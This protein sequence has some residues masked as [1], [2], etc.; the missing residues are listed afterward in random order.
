M[1]RRHGYSSLLLH[2]RMKNFL[3]LIILASLN[4]Q[5]QVA[6]VSIDEIRIPADDLLLSDGTV[7]SPEDAWS[8]LKEK[9]SD[10]LKGKDLP[11]SLIDLEP[12]ENKL[13]KNQIGAK[14]DKS[15]DDID[16]N[17]SD[18]VT[19]T[20]DLT[21]KDIFRF[22]AL[23]SE[24]RI[25][26][27]YLDKKMHVT[28]MRK[29]FLR[30]LGY[31]VPA[32]KHLEKLRVNFK[33]NDEK[34]EFISKLQTAT[35]GR[36]TRWVVE[37]ESTETSLF[38]RDVSA[39]QLN[40]QQLYNPAMG[41]PS[42]SLNSRT[43]R[44]LIIPYS[45]LN[46]G[47][48]ANKLEWTVGSIK[49]NKIILPHFFSNN[50]F[51]SAN[52]NDVMWMLK[53]IT[54]LTRSDYEEVV[55]NSN[56]PKDVETL[57]VEKIIS[58]TRSLFDLLKVKY[59][60]ENFNFDNK[61]SNPPIL[62]NGRIKKK[63]WTNE[64]YASEF[65][66]GDATSPF[67]D[68]KYYF[69]S[70]LQSV[71]LDNIISKFNSYLR[72]FDPTKARLDL[73][74]KEF[75]QGLNHFVETGELLQFPVSAW[76]SPVLQGSVILSRDVVV[77]NYLGTENLVQLA[78]TFGYAI[79]P[80][81]V[82]GL[83]NISGLNSTS[84]SAGLSYVKTFTHL[85]PL[86]SLKDVFKEDYRNMIVP[87]L[88]RNLRKS[89][90]N[91]EKRYET[92][93]ADVE[94]YIN[95][96]DDYL[97]QNQEIFSSLTKDLLSVYKE[98][99]NV[100]EKTFTLYKEKL[101]K[102]LF[103][104]LNLKNIV[105]SQRDHVYRKKSLTT[106]DYKEMLKS[107]PIQEIYNPR[108]ESVLN[109]LDSVV[110]EI[111]NMN[112]KLQKLNSE[113][114]DFSTYKKEESSNEIKDTVKSL[115]EVTSQYEE[116]VDISKK[117]RTQTLD[118]HK[119]NFLSNTLDLISKRLGVGESLIIS[120]RFSQNVGGKTKFPIVNTGF[121]FDLGF[122]VGHVGVKR[123]QILRKDANTIQIYDDKGNGFDLEYSISFSNKIPLIRFENR[124]FNGKY[125]VKSYFLN[126]SADRQKNPDFLKNASLLHGV[127]DNG[128]TEVLEEVSPPVV[129]E[130][131]FKDKY[132]RFAFLFWR[133]KGT[134][135]FV[136]YKLQTP[137]GRSENYVS[138][139]SNV[140]RGLN[141]E[142]FTKDLV[143]F[144]FSKISSDVEWANDIWARTGDTILGKGGMSEYSYEA[145][146]KDGKIRNEYISI[147]TQYKGWSKK[148]N[149]VVKTALKL[150]KDYELDL[151]DPD[152]IRNVNK[153]TLYDM[154][155]TL[156]IYGKG[157][158]ALKSLSQLK[159]VKIASSL[160]FS[161]IEQCK[162]RESTVSYKL[163][164]G[165]EVITCGSLHSSIKKINKCKNL[166]SSKSKMSKR[167][168]CWAKFT[169]VLFREIG[170]QNFSKIIG[171]K[172]YYVSGQINGFRKE[173]E[174][175]RDPIYSNAFGKR[176]KRFP[177]G[178]ISKA[179]SIVGVSGGEFEGFWLRERP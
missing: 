124:H 170:F 31:N 81:F 90:D 89:L 158:R 123:M 93:V 128:S 45:I 4:L 99:K 74:E 39:I 52:Y 35:A 42:G 67:K 49:E 150:N 24:N 96:Y 143:N 134:R 129:I 104:F 159:L 107:E 148:E 15:L 97:E 173:S 174:K 165:E 75:N 138:F 168:A 38:L 146:V 34:K 79:A 114:I 179:Q 41:T 77:G 51:H 68:Y 27:F 98:A 111:S 84:F 109:I 69:Y 119:D 103:N 151:F 54:S 101:T 30:K 64:G 87:L 40:D 83:E 113:T 147:K 80:G 55:R 133:R 70:I 162:R 161:D 7:L 86:L 95:A 6:R 76:S 20:D 108:S 43:L 17:S 62:V 152:K 16:I 149:K 92:K 58:R 3:A 127:L 137:N 175:L 85:K 59:N 46:M 167:T 115:E 18:T 19:F 9:P 73:A 160:D 156:S 155:V 78:D 166:D 14:L 63:D 36:S 105:E 117:S 94:G 110:S 126:I 26:T 53:K 153:L 121:T 47:E 164:N 33:S 169:N 11:K 1:L 12:R 48:S 163:S 29:N 37:D 22:T 32:M 91:V 136:D 60:K 130:G 71:A 112:S 56:F 25:K 100:K 65:A 82:V 102:T 5:A 2:R 57:V 106:K 8:I 21:S 118:T 72:V 178:I 125:K 116:I 172:N 142:S 145:Q 177:N 140:E 10:A 61:P 144:Y 120:E 141:W 176:D 154:N 66:A 28:L 122:G 50:L 131:D 88:K 135:G 44:A 139:R 23:D 132:S 157:V 171:E 13:W